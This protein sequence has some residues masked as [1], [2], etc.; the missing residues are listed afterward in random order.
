M[1]PTVKENELPFVLLC[2]VLSSTQPPLE[3]N[4]TTAPTP[5][6]QQPSPEKK[7]KMM[8]KKYTQA[9]KISTYVHTY[10]HTDS[11]PLPPAFSWEKGK[12]N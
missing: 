3:K 2:R 9:H 4:Q 12:N 1:L 7:F 6:P 10:E 8:E 5:T 11:P